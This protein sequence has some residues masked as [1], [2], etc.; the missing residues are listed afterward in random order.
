MTKLLLRL[1]V[2]D[3]NNTADPAVRASIGKLGGFTGI[4]CN[5]LL[6]IA[7][8]SA[9]F[10]SGAVSI[11][12]DALNNLSDA[13]S[14]IVTVLGFRL[15]Q[16]PADKEHP[17]G[18]ARYE[19]LCGLA[20]SVL[21]LVLGAEFA[22]SSVK[23]IITPTQVNISVLTL[24]ILFCSIGL[25]AW[26]AV[27][28]RS[29]AKK[30]N[31]TAL[32]ANAADSRNDVIATSAV[33]LCGLLRFFFDLN[34]DG[35]VGLAVAIFIFYSGIQAAKKTLT[36][37]LGQQADA[38][39]IE[40]LEKLI[41]SHENILGIHDLLVHDYGPGKHFASVHA[42]ISAEVDPLCCHE[43]IDHI[44]CDVLEQL[45]VHL[46]IHYDPV[47]L[48]DEEQNRMRCVVE[49]IVSEFGENLSV[50]DFRLVRC[51]Q[52][53]KLVFDLAIPYDM[54]KQSEDL[55]QKIDEALHARGMEYVTVIRF[56]E[57]A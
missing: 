48:Y 56:D 43:L 37:L 39:Q 7:K 40:Q 2:K 50:H 25:K 45:N 9:G 15:S 5:I 28:Y 36:P 19:Y 10:L 53:T 13:T 22:I 32:F 20:V 41:L 35:Y 4:V 24:V 17:Y 1:F 30:I 54:H 14:S 57:T 12:A 18:H 27:F 55:K 8:L 29:L 16:Q 33:L 23:K 51:P 38:K 34:I 44:E 49:D 42:E 26:M 21:I 11:T 52:Q 31:S 6:S 47:E 3:Y 46:V